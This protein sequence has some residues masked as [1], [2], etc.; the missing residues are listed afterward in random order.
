MTQVHSSANM[1]VPSQKN[2]LILTG[3]AL[4]LVIAATIIFGW[5]VLQFALVSYVVSFVIEILFA[6]FRKKNLDI[7]WY[8]TPMFFTLLL[9]PLLPLWMAGVGAAFGVFFGKAI[10]GGTGK[11]IFNPALVGI[12]FLYVTFPIQLTQEWIVPTVDLVAGATPLKALSSTGEFYY[13]ISS[14]LFGNQYGSV[15]ETFRLGILILGIGLIILKVSNWRIPLSYL[16]TVFIIQLI[17]NQLNPALFKDPLL[18]LLTG[19]L[20]LGAFFFATDLTS[21][22]KTNRGMLLFGLGLGVLT[23]MIRVYATFVEGV[24][25]SIII[26]SAISPLLDKAPK[27]ILIKEGETNEQ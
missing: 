14:L 6:K 26:M 15:G 27:E 22:P 12:L 4:I 21:A 3:F 11:T 24:T 25:F 20:L 13:T 5:I 16:G 1:S 10:F 7:G 18:S 19:G 2:L 23:V 17:G 9:P 8:V